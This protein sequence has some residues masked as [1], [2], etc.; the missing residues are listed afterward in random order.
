MFCAHKR[1]FSSKSSRTRRPL[2]SKWSFVFL[3][4]GQFCVYVV[5]THILSLWKCPQT[6]TYLNFFI[7]SK[8]KLIWI[9]VLWCYEQLKIKESFTKRRNSGIQNPYDKGFFCNFAYVLCSSHTP[10]L[11]NLRETIP[12]KFLNENNCNY[13]GNGN[14]KASNNYDMTMNNQAGFDR[15]DRS[16]VSLNRESENERLPDQLRKENSTANG[17]QLKTE[18]V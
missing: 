12:N 10:S 6:K 4:C 13:N 5:I 11:L 9:E 18:F 7:I 2:L 1:R 3:A 17:S 15:I 14:S 16:S 8:S